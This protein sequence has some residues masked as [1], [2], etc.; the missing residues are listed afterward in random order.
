MGAVAIA[1]SAAAIWM[2]APPRAP[3][4]PPPLDPRD[5]ELAYERGLDL[6]K[7]GRH[8]ESVPEFRGALHARP[9]LW[10]FHHDY[11]TALFNTAHESRSHLGRLEP[12][13][14]SSVER[15][16]LIREGLTE[17]EAARQ[18]ARDPR[19]HALI[20]HTRAQVFKAWGLPWNAFESFS[21][22]PD[23]TWRESVLARRL[24]EAMEDPTGEH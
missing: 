10:N 8:R 14:R 1:L 6:A 23:T 3:V 2:L 13:M 12:V 11:A 21:E 7:A 15:V 9:D 19:E 5:A 24:M 20:I 17:L 4:A 22:W 18:R 16:A